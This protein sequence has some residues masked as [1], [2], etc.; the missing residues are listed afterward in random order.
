MSHFIQIGFPYVI[1][2]Q[3]ITLETG[4]SMLIIEQ[5]QTNYSVVILFLY[6]LSSKL[7]TMECLC[8]LKLTSDFNRG[9]L[10]GTILCLFL[11]FCFFFR[12]EYFLFKK[13][14]LN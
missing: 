12:N 10:D 6:I 11:F 4:I 5:L 13:D 1:C 7:Q 9:Y 8:A 2:A 14:T 3:L